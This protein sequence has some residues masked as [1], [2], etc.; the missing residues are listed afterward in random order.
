MRGK[1]YE[2]Q[3]SLRHLM[4]KRKRCTEIFANGGMLGIGSFMA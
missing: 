3:D 2:K 4:L 1:G